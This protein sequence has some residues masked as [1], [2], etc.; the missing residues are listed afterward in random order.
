MV[1]KKTLTADNEL[2]IACLIECDFA[3]YQTRELLK[4]LYPAYVEQKKKIKALKEWI[5][6][7]DRIIK[8]YRRDDKTD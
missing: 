1:D 2:E 6:T 8:R 5:E 3:I 7:Q 4:R